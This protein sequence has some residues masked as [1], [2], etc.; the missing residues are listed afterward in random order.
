MSTA[1]TVAQHKLSRVRVYFRPRVLTMLLL[2]FS[3][4]MP[5][6]LT[7]NTLGYWLRDEGTSLTAIGFLSWVGIAYS[8]KPLYAPIIDRLDVPLLGRLGRRRGWM[9]LTQ[10][11]VCL[12]LIAMSVTGPHGGLTLLG[13]SALL[14]A[15]ASS[16]QDIVVDAWRIEVA[17]NGDELGLLSSAYQLGYRI[18]IIITESLIL[19]A[20]G[21]FGWPISYSVMAA[22]MVIGIAATLKATEPRRAEAAMRT[23]AATLP[24]W[25]IRGFSDAVV[26][27]FIVF[28]KTY[29]L[30]AILMLLMISLYRV[31]DFIRGP[32]QNPFYHDLGLSKDVV[33]GVR[34]SVGLLFAFLGIAAGG[35]SSARFG[36]IKTL[37]AGAV[38]QAVAISSFSIM[39]FRGADVQTFTAI[40]AADDFALSFAGVALVTYMS[41]LTSLGYTATQYALLSS[42]YV[43]LGKIL[44]GT[45]GA[46]V[47]YLSTHGHTL[48]GAYGIFFIGA[49]AI[50]IP[51]LILCVF[52]TRVQKRPPVTT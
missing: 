18:A 26:G 22:L 35:L 52:L 6:Y 29:G 43:Y 33:G 9:L 21:H 20:A 3:S 49:G 16:A 42:T 28:F 19:I 37:V 15:F 8:L 7:G 32:M 47:E 12:G 14:V 10:L 38:F 11:F 4:G 27:P 30:T 39:A 17:D 48:M 23:K 44:K 31:P 45:S 24:L 13:A 2:G 25:S 36:Y 1:E 46:V 34:A 41:S 40:M 5:F 50:G 51:G